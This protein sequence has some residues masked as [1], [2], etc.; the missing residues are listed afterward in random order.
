VQRSPAL[1]PVICGVA[2]K[3]DTKP[4]I[5]SACYASEYRHAIVACVDFPSAFTARRE[6]LL[7]NPPVARCSNPCRCRVL[8]SR[9]SRVEFLLP[10]RA[11]GV[12]MVER[13][14]GDISIVAVAIRFACG[15]PTESGARER[16]VR[17]HPK[18][19]CVNPRVASARTSGVAPGAQ[20][21]VRARRR[22][23]RDPAPRSV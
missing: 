4:N 22:A 6:R 20:P 12:V 9:S 1:S 11:V 15:R 18:P 3:L 19:A 14:T 7:R 10:N 17:F 2:G 16:N 8:A 23:A 5:A 21:P 13:R